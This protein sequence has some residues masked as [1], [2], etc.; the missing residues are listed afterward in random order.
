MF[1]EPCHI[2][3]VSF[4]KGNLDK[5][6]YVYWSFN[7]LVNMYVKACEIIWHDSL[8]LIVKCRLF[9]TQIIFYLRD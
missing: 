9:L 4:V 5:S 3:V 1:R 6:I 8:I 7:Y 2:Y